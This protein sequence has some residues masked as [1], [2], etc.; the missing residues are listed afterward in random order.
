M[1]N[2]TQVKGSTVS[3]I[4]PNYNYGHLLPEAVESVLRQTVA[5]EE[6]L[7][8]DDGSQDNSLEMAEQ[9]KGEIKIVKNEKNL[10]IIA[11]F[12]KAVSL[13]QGDY[14][15]FLGADNRFRSDYVEKCKLALDQHPDCAIVYT[16]AFLFGP[17]A[18]VFAQR[19]GARP[20]S[21]S[22]EFFLWEFPAFSEEAKRTLRQKNIIHGSSMYRR[23]VFEQVGGYRDSQGPEDQNLFA[24]MLEKG[25]N[26]ILRKDYLLEYRHHSNQQDCTR[27]ISA[28]EVAQLRRQI[29]EKDALIQQLAAT[30]QK[31]KQISGEKG[32][33]NLSQASSRAPISRGAFAAPKGKTRAIA[34][35]LPQFH[36]IPENDIWWEKD[37]PNGRMSPRQNLYFPG[38]ISRIFPRI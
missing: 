33:P 32:K 17:M 16:N 21:N 5:P 7:F 35:Y 25:W 19:F 14:I 31:Y 6:I 13:T 38:I 29:K 26:A 8:I 36:P 2:D 22:R 28:M 1:V 10:G 23:K 11:N 18:E 30:L 27:R 24:R 15:S 3:V 34:F 12:N 9:Y 4:I 20:L 37:L